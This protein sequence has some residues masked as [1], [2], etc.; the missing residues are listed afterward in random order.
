MWNSGLEE[1][2]AGWV[3]LLNITSVFTSQITKPLLLKEWDYR[4][5]S[6]LIKRE[7]KNQTKTTKLSCRD[8]GK[9]PECFSQPDEGLETKRNAECVQ[10][11]L[12]QRIYCF[13]KANSLLCAILPDRAGPTPLIS[14]I[15]PQ[16]LSQGHPWRP[17]AG[18][19][20]AFPS[21]VK[22]RT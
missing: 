14:L 20:R 9:E 21:W 3:L 19:S 2:A 8:T 12:F 16:S 6:S 15:D 5:I 10:Y 11:L 7:K 22:N 17:R 18:R 4:R 13:V 1:A